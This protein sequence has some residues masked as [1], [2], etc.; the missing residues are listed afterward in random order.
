MNYPK[1]IRVRQHLDRKKVD[2]PYR[3]MGEQLSSLPESLIRRGARIA[4]TA[5]SRC[6][7]NLAPITK[8]VIDYIAAKGGHPFIVPAMGSHGGATAEGQVRVLA[9]FGL[10]EEGLGAPIRSSM[11]AIQLG[12]VDN[13]P[14]YI[15]K[16][17]RTADGI[18]VINRI[19]AHQ[20][21]KG[22][23]Q[24][25]LNKM[26]V[27][28]L[29]K[30]KGADVVHASGRTDV[31]GPMGDF[32]RGVTPVLFGVA[33]LENSYDE[34]RDAAVVTPDRFTEYDIAWAKQSRSLMPKIPVRQLDLVI[35]G[36]MGKDVSGSGM[37]TNVIGFTRRML[38][39]GQTAVP[40]A[41][42]DLTEKT[43]GNAM[44]IGLADFTTRRLVEN[45]DYR[46]TYT[47]VLA[48]GIYSTGRIPL[49]FESDREIVDTVIG[50]LANPE[51]A[52]IIRLKN[53]LEL[54][55]FWAT[56]ALR[57]E[58]LGQP[59]LEIDGDAVET[60]FDEQGNIVPDA[61]TGEIQGGTQNPGA[62]CGG[63]L[64]RR[65]DPCR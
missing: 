53:T 60:R 28:G 27:V 63:P 43:E 51:K 46:K 48:T 65:E 61:E 62:L 6:I 15:D 59:Q 11:E 26:L 14:A 44:G 4:V 17:A 30:Q 12:V 42:L 55:R 29:G 52:R 19:K 36:R 7:A 22:D 40:L 16:H 13:I 31:L 33:I 5:G 64:G 1:W 54:D 18:V 49:T 34:T 21:F 23:I 45:I 50:K 10:T 2:D 57:E 37:D 56:E 35:V 9:E 3:A 20:V 8:A 25:G 38:A 41:V 58:L 47:N 39:S 24:S 32:I